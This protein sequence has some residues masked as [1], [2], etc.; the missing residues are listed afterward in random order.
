MMFQDSAAALDPR[1]T[2]SALVEEPLAQGAG[3]RHERRAE[4]AEL[5]EAVGLPED[6]G[7]RFPHE[8][9]GGQRQRIAMARERSRSGRRSLS[10]TSRC[11]RSTSPS[12]PR[13]ST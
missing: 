5:V 6:A 13:S 10:R 3:S 11:P 4:V 12:R 8:F 1:M 9:S 2:V 7:E